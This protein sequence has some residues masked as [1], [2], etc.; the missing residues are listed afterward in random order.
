M[1]WYGG[2][3][4]YTPSALNIAGIVQPY[5]QIFAGATSVGPLVKAQAGI[6]V[7]ILRNIYLNFGAEYGMLIYRVENNYYNSRNVGGTMGLKF[8]F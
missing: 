5:T 8:S 2:F 6:S 4:N 1:L 7:N 3:W